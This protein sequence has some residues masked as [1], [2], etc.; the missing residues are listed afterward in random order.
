MSAT[1]LID[2]IATAHRLSDV[3]HTGGV[4]GQSRRVAAMF[5]HRHIFQSSSSLA[6]A[7]APRFCLRIKGAYPRAAVNAL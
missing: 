1:T 6:G 7:P 2:V 3:A 4:K 5:I